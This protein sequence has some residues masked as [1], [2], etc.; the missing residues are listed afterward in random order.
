M[1]GKITPKVLLCLLM[2]FVLIQYTTGQTARGKGRLSGE[3]VDQE[4]KAVVGAKVVIEYI[5]DDTAVHD[6]TTDKRGNFGFIALGTGRWKITATLEGFIPAA[7]EVYVRQLERNPKVTVTLQKVLETDRPFV[8]N[9]ESFEFLDKGNKLYEDGKYKEAL[10]AYEEF[11]TLN[12]KAYQ[13]RLNLY[14]CFRELGDYEKAREQCNLVLESVSTEEAAGKEMAAKALA[15]IGECYLKEQDIENAQKYFEQSINTYPENELTAYNVG[16][17]FFANQKLDEA[18]KYF[19]IAKDIKPDWSD[20][21]YK[22]GLVYLNLANYDEAKVN[23]EKFLTLEK[24]T[25]R[26]ASVKNIL[27]Q[28]K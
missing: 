26:A 18:L 28:L 16:E 21:Y 19:N 15:G 20:A 11:L 6:T 4:G 2:L 8:E 17:I 14:N 13:V 22:L 9:E 10:L 27:N 1:R 5:G 25:E 12:P 7:T 3:V 24:D 23:L